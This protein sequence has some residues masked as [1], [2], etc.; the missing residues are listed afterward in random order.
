[1]Y[2]CIYMYVCLCTCVCMYACKYVFFRLS[3]SLSYTLFLSPLSNKMYSNFEKALQEEN[4]ALKVR[5]AEQAGMT[6][7]MTSNY[8]SMCLCIIS[9]FNIIIFSL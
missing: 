3:P 8:L 2:V 6:S 5:L 7:S 1:M 4:E 9:L